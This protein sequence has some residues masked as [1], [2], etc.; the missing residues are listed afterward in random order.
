MP[1]QTHTHDGLV[2]GHVVSIQLEV[3]L[4]AL[5]VIVL[6]RRFTVA[7]QRR[8]FTYF[9]NQM[10]Q[11]SSLMHSLHIFPKSLR[12][13]GG[14]AR[15]SVGAGYPR[16]GERSHDGDCQEGNVDSFSLN[17]RGKPIT[18]PGISVSSWT[19]ST[20]AN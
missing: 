8:I 7:A 9:P 5:G 1:A 16:S 3:W 14:D 12:C 15:Q 18:G 19:S 11:C 2:A 10:V 17:R 20:R 4:N 6:Q 13:F